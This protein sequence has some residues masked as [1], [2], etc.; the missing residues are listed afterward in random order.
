MSADKIRT[1]EP[2]D[3]KLTFSER[4][5]KD[6]SENVQGVPIKLTEFQIKITLKIFGRED[7]FRYF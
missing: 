5:F 4:K 6:L 7:Q 1:T 2:I 3:M